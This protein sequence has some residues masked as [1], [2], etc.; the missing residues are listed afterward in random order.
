MS[1][2][3]NLYITN[4]HRNRGNTRLRAAAPL[5]N[6][7]AQLGDAGLNLSSHEAGSGSDTASSHQTD[8]SK[9]MSHHR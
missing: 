4:R 5:M 2:C 6:V 7:Q 1:P 9:R 8:G 3:H